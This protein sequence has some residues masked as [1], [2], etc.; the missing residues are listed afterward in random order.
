MPNFWR[1]ALMNVT[2][3][4]EDIQEWD[5]PVL[6]HLKNIYRELILDEENR[7]NEEAGFKLIFEFEEN[8]YF[9]NEKLVRVDIFW[10]LCYQKR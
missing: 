4:E 7:P 9:E 5:V 1:E 8:P 3:L 2:S 10:S 6:N